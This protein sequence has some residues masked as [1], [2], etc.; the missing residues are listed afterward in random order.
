[1]GAARPLD[2]SGSARSSA[3]TSVSFTISRSIL[4]P[5]HSVEGLLE[6][7]SRTGALVRLVGWMEREFTCVMEHIPSGRRRDFVTGMLDAA[8]ECDL[9]TRLPARGGD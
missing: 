5:G 7:A 9:T 4:P 2:G 8:A 6:D 3:P 1:M